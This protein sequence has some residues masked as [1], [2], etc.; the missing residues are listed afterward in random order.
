[1]VTFTRNIY[2]GLAL[3][4]EVYIVSLFTTDMVMMFMRYTAKQSFRGEKPDLSD[5]ISFGCVAT[6]VSSR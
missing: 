3:D 4:Y 5:Q 6:V 2:G 1:M